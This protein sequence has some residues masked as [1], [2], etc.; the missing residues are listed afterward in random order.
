MKRKNFDIKNFILNMNKQCVQNQYMYIYYVK[1]K[2]C[3]VNDST[4]TPVHSY[5]NCILQKSFYNQM[6]DFCII[7]NF[8]PLN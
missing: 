5:V 4:D 6:P 1:K 8:F 2:K 3:A 7:L